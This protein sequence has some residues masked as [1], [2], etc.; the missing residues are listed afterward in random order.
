MGASSQAHGRVFAFHGVA[1]ARRE[2]WSEQL[3]QQGAVVIDLSLKT[4]T[5]TTMEN[6]IYIVTD[7]WV[8]VLPHLQSVSS[9]KYVTEFWLQELLKSTTWIPPHTNVFF[10]PPPVDRSQM[11]SY[12]MHYRTW[13]ERSGANEE[14]S[15]QDMLLPCSPM[16]RWRDSVPMWPYFVAYLTQPMSS[17]QELVR[18]LQQLIGRTDRRLNCLERAIDQMLTPGERTALFTTVIP[19]MRQLVLEMP[20]RFPSPPQL[21]TPIF[22]LQASSSSAP[23]TINAGPTE[24]PA[25]HSVHF[26]REQML[27]FMSAAFFCV[28]PFQGRRIPKSQSIDFPW[29]SFERMYSVP[30]RG[31]ES[32]ELKAHKIRTVLE[33]FLRVVPRF[34][35]NPSPIRAQIVTFSR[36]AINMRELSATS[37]ASASNSSLQ[38]LR[39]RAGGRNDLATVQMAHVDVSTDCLIEDAEQHLQIDFANKYAGGGVMN[40]GCVQEEIRFILSPELL[41]SCLVF[42]RLESHEAFVI[43]GTERFS[44][45]SG[46]GSTYTFA[47]G[48]EDSTPFHDVMVQAHGT[49]VAGLFQRRQNVVVGIDA[50][51]YSGRDVIRQY[52]R[53]CVWRDLVKALVGFSYTEGSTGSWPIATGNWGC[54]VFCGDPELKFLIQWLAASLAGRVSVMY[55]IFEQSGYLQSK[56]RGVLEQQRA[57]ALVDPT[58]NEQFA[59]WIFEFLLALEDR[60]CATVN[61]RQPV[62]QQRGRGNTLSSP[63]SVLEEACIFLETRYATLKERANG[64]EDRTAAT[65]SS[66]PSRPKQSKLT[67]FWKAEQ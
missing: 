2:R 37:T 57:F 48:V 62:R 54:G 41:V 65:E 47:G 67:S 5:T 58:V 23:S 18:V 35:V 25:S 24:S 43:H 21:L 9:L 46:Y 34:V 53:E 56:I 14:E 50:I 55:V 6:A 8:D 16:H 27:V 51:S 59:E 10:R 29:F 17:T 64:D 7:Y 19:T 31:R 26:T 44:N 66:G 42:A 60:W 63:K 38:Q 33:Y 13:S 45:Y 49:E 4:L 3:R 39:E 36:V 20:F 15:S 30:E 52:S 32:T 28:F 40:S 11:V 1:R 61:S 22:E 12:P